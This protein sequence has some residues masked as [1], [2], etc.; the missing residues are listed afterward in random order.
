MR[1]I[2][3]WLLRVTLATLV[4]TS[5]ARAGEF[6]PA[7]VGGI[8]GEYV[9]RLETRPD[10]LPPSDF[11]SLAGDLARSYD[12]SLG[13]VCSTT[14]GIFTVHMTEEQARRLAEDPRIRYVEQNSQPV[15]PEPR[16]LGEE[17]CPVPEGIGQLGSC[18]TGG[19]PQS[20]DCPVHD[21]RDPGYDC[22][23]N[24]GLDR[25][26][27]PNLPRDNEY[28]YQGQGEGVHVYVIDTGIT[29]NHGEFGD[30]VEVG[31]NT[32]VFPPNQNVTDCIAHSH[33]T[34]VSAIIGGE[35]YG[36]AK[37]VTLHPVKWRDDCPGGPDPPGSWNSIC[38]GLDWIRQTH[39]TGK[40]TGPAVVNL[41]LNSHPVAPNTPQSVR[42][43]VR[44]VLDAGISVVQSAGNFDGNACTYSLGGDAN[45]DEVIV[46]GGVDVSD[47]NGN[48]VTGR[49]RRE[50]PTTTGSPQQDPSWFPY[51]CPTWPNACPFGGDCGSNFGNC[52]DL[53][54]PAGH[55]VSASKDLGACRL[56]GTSMA[57]PHVTGAL[58]LY[59]EQNT[60]AS[61]AQ[62]KQAILDAIEPGVLDTTQGSPYHIGTNS[63][64]KL[65][66]VATMPPEG[67][68]F[69]DD[70]ET[71][72]T[73]LW[74][75][76]E[77]TPNGGD[78]EVIQDPFPPS[79]VLAIS[80]QADPQCPPANPNPSP[81]Y[82]FVIDQSPQAE[83]EYGASFAVDLHGLG[84]GTSRIV[85]AAWVDQTPT[86]S[87][88]LSVRL[89]NTGPNPDPPHPPYTNQLRLET[90]LDDGTPV[91]LPWADF[92]AS[93]NF[94]Y[95]HVQWTAASAPGASDGSAR[96][97]LDGRKA[98]VA[99][100]LDNDQR[101]IDL[102]RFGLAGSPCLFGIAG[103][104][105]LDGFQ[106]WRGPAPPP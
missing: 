34:H 48:D 25:I 37:G 31:I 89:R 24:W 9:V 1:Q 61:P 100:G 79:Y 56:S 5:V 97:W 38:R 36:V 99:V 96:L 51:C 60:G 4:L 86:T 94:N 66:Q 102:V 58:A 7:S 41:S 93:L 87:V 77:F 16:I 67:F 35:C 49:W 14:V 17:M 84:L 91:V 55:I 50:G 65:L 29:T 53:W 46:V 80:P 2:T 43:M 101:A 71:G 30:R 63:P 54:A 98:G 26:D 59:L 70:F 44:E 45:L 27:Q 15:M 6:L 103:T 69:N 20:I 11:L 22:Q 81:P 12:G 13:P 88:V 76:G 74:N 62:A 39:G 23:D 104:Y 47:L 28:S 52:V 106:S 82:L 8:E 21:P 92:A 78:L 18:L 10:E 105:Y 42:D 85:L 32:S 33:G 75:G 19:S 83:T 3:K 57:A 90:Y 72:D 40:Q 73:S 95:V 64:N 68:I